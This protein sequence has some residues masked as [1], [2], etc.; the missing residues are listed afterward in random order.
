[1]LLL[2]VSIV[3]VIR[4]VFTFCLVRRIDV[5]TVYVFSDKVI[6]GTDVRRGR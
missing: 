1:M 6:L 5:V 2:G 3:P 4:I